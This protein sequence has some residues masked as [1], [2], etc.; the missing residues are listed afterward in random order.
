MARPA[1]DAGA[2]EKRSTAPPK[3]E[4]MQ[5]FDDWVETCSAARPAPPAGR[6]ALGA[7][8]EVP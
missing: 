4:A 3:A 5:P 7:G 6:H 2:G 1:P 8:D